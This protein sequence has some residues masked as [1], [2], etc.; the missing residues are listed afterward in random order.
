MQAAGAPMPLIRAQVVAP[1]SE[2]NTY[3][4]LLRRTLV[5]ILP[6][7]TFFGR[8][9]LPSRQQVPLAPLHVQFLRRVPP[10]STSRTWIRMGSSIPADLHGPD[11]T[12]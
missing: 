6:R 2:S 3:V 4:H 7:D 11:G 1:T 10:G 5:A 8:I 12:T 9:Q